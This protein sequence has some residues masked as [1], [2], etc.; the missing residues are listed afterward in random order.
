MEEKMNHNRA[1]Y[2]IVFAVL[3]VTALFVINSA[4]ATSSLPTKVREARAD[5][6]DIQRWVAKGDYYSKLPASGTSFEAELSRNA[7]A[8]RLQALGESY[9]TSNLWTRQADAARWQALGEYYLNLSASD[10]NFDATFSRDTAAAR[11]DGLGKYYTDLKSAEAANQAHAAL[12][13]AA[14]YTGEALEQFERSGDKKMLPDCI[15]ADVMAELPGNIGGNRWK[16]LVPVC[17]Q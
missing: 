14:R 4:Y 8:A 9:F 5:Q 7:D 10:A 12:V 2:L 11:W 3:L 15:T 17:G 13:S 16:S 6:A 1:I